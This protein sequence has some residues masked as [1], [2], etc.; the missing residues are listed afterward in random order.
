MGRRP[1]DPLRALTDAERA[2]L[3][4]LSRSSTEPAA[5][6][7]R[8]KAVLAVANGGSFTAAARAA[9]RR[10]G[11]AVGH[12]VARFNRVGLAALEARHGGGQPKRYT[13]EDQARILREARRAPDREEDG[14][15]TWSLAT[16]QAAL[17]TAPDGLPTVSTFTIWA[18]LH[19][20]GFRWGKDRSWCDTGTVVR[21]R[22]SGPV[23]V[24][25][26]DTV[27]KNVDRGGLRAG[28]PSGL[29]RRWSRTVPNHPVPGSALASRRRAGPVPARVCP[30]GDS[31]AVD[32]LPPGHRRGAGRRGTAGLERHPPSLAADRVDRDPGDPAPARHWSQSGDPTPRLGALAGRAQQPDHPTAGAAAAAT[33]P[34]ARQSGR[35]PNASIR[36]VAVR[37]RHHAV[38][39][40]ARRQLVEHGRIDPAHPQA[41]RAGRPASDSSGPDH[42]L[43]GGRRP[44]LESPAHPIRLGR[45]PAN[46]TPTCSGPAAPACRLR[47]DH[48]AAPAT[49]TNGDWR[50]PRQLTH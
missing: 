35:A 22:K 11:D 24:S 7:A 42:H 26:P 31:E 5:R 39:H 2:Q 45:R 8:A 48:P 23:L 40:V 14:T 49:S 50:C 10:S 43:A 9:G 29:D 38:V 12:L 1:N 15:A 18:V 27:A 44:G 17:R 33:P 25:D 28:L 3:E 32:A 36:P 20:A 6:V 34:G 21:K 16:L 46:A 4:R 30:S 37:P 19:D 13:A 41:T 47:R